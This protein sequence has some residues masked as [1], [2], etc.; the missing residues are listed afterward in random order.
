MTNPFY[1]IGPQ[2]TPTIIQIF[3]ILTA[4]AS[5]FSALQV[6]FFP[7]FPL[8]YW[9]NLSWT[10]MQEHFFWQPL[11]YLFLVQ[12]DGATVSF[13]FNW[14]FHLYLLWIFGTSLIERV[15]TLHFL[16][17]FF[18]GG[19]C[20]GFLGLLI[21][22][23]S[24]PFHLLSGSSIALY[25]ILVAWVMLNPTAE[26]R[27]FFA[28]PFKVKWLLYGFLG[29][30]LL[31]SLSEWDFVTFVSYFTG[32]FF[33][34][35]YVLCLYHVHSPLPFLHE[36]EK[37][38]IAFFRKR[39]ERKIEKRAKAFREAKVVNIKTGRALLSDEE[40]ESAMLSKISLYGESVLTEEEKKRLHKIPTRKKKH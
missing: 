33:G 10:G 2:K 28:I 22:S 23:L 38:V 15:G 35:L 32:A 16:I 19:L 29:L 37:R 34:Y 36:T 11:S 39:K 18:G 8:Q 1:K 17:L 5:L 4:I 14:A 27:L 31:I 7:N 21:M 3:L 9:L 30:P 26:M 12:S 24:Y 20:A 6:S 25:S 13:F 40:F